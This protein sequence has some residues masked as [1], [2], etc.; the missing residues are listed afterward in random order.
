MSSNNPQAPK[1]TPPYVN[2]STRE[3]PKQTSPLANQWVA[4]GFIYDP[5][6]G[7]VN[8]VPKSPTPDVEE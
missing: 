8:P 3:F 7:L 4:T 1:P 6:T 2:P 5:S